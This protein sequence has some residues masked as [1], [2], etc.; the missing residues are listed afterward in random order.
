M[1]FFRIKSDIPCMRHALVFNIISL[2]T[3]L[4]AVFFL[5]SRG[6]HYS[7]EF[8]GGTLVE[9][10]YAEAPNLESIR[11]QL[12]S[13][14]FN[15]IQ[16]QNFGSSRDVL[17]RVPL[18]KDTETSKVGERVLAAIT[19]VGAG[20]TPASAAPTLKRDEFVGNSPK[21]VPWHCSWLFSVLSFIWQFDSN[22]ASRF[23]RSLPICTTSSLSLAFLPCSS[24]SFRC[25]FWR[26]SWLCLAIQ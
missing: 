18:T 4:L 16:V 3:F 7:V 26:Q 5:A 13:G 15:D 17:I 10:S 12:E 8:T 14:G 20:S 9:A 22:G 19:P 25:Q 24:G 11:K 6:L 2:V 1:E 21:T 23:P